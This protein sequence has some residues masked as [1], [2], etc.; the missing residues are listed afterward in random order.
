MNTSH[1]WKF[2]IETIKQRLS[3]RNYFLDDLCSENKAFLDLRT[4]EVLKSNRFIQL[5]ES[6]EQL[7]VLLSDTKSTATSDKQ[8]IQYIWNELLI[9]NYLTAFDPDIKFKESD[10]EAHHIPRCDSCLKA[11]LDVAERYQTITPELGGQAILDFF[12]QYQV[13]HL[14]LFDEFMGVIIEAIDDDST[15]NEF[16]I[17]DVSLDILFIENLLECNL[18]S[19]DE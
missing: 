17:E 6:Q 4:R 18:S 16:P 12:Q 11:L 3:E 7:E 10:D 9:R 8:R 15:D 13:I 1:S 14:G 2:S 19:D 5:L